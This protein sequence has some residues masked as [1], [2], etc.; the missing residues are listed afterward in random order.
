MAN[1]RLEA[2]TLA[3]WELWWNMGFTTAR[4]TPMELRTAAKTWEEARA[5]IRVA[6]AR[7]RVQYGVRV[8]PEQR[9]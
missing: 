9:E 3:T 1:K 5:A 7:E 6:E 8:L 2:I 4:E